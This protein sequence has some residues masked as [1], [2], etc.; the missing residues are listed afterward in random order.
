[1]KTDI[2]IAQSV[3]LKPIQLL[4]AELGLTEDEIIP[5]GKH[6]AKVPLGLLD[7][8]KDRPDGK[9]ILV[10]ASTPPAQGAGKTTTTIG[11]GQAFAR[12]GRRAIVC[13]REPSLGPCM[14]MKGGATGGGYAQVLPM[15]EINLHFTGDLHAVTMAHNLLAAVVDNH[16]HQHSEPSIH[17][18]HVVWKRVLDMNDRSLRHIIVG[19]LDQG[20]NGVMRE[21][22]F[23]ITAAS[24]VMAILCLSDGLKD[25]KERLGRIIVGY[26]ALRRPITARDLKIA[27]AMAALLKNA[28]HPNLVQTMEGTPAFVHGGPFA[29]IAHGCSSLAATRMGLKLG[30]FVVTEAGFAADLG[31]EKFFDIKCRF[32]RLQPAVAVVV[33]P[34]LAYT[35]HGLENIVKHVQNIRAF[36]VP[37]V[38]SINRYAADREEDLLALRD[39]CR[40]ADVEAVITDFRERGGSGGLELAEKIAGLCDGR[41]P[42]LKPLYP[43]EMSLVEKIETIAVKIYG[44]GKVVFAEK[45]RKEIQQIE[46]LGFRNV[47]VCMAKTPL[48]L[49]DDP[50]IAGTPRGFTLNVSDARISAGAGFV[51]V[52]TGNIMTMPGLPE[53]PAAL[54]IDIDDAGVISGLG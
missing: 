45:A 22:G 37:A 7:R 39:A 48:S 50:K 8:L 20:A 33:V 13:V 29:N 25:L 16:L 27:G 36:N 42:G 2:E 4:A 34:K 53:V 49:T 17:P 21:S 23:E 28:I 54:N 52:Y 1:M 3:K 47:P 35:T 40:Q 12:L 44:A 26:D 41:T 51:V 43:L 5:Y 31:A 6:I 18:R 10:T 24:E 32:G 15:E 14:G 46:N 38:V 30:D 9:L 19:L 11:L